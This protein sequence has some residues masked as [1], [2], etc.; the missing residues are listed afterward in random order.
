MVISSG[1][2]RKPLQ[3]GAVVPASGRE[4][5]ADLVD[6]DGEGWVGGGT[7]ML[8]LRLSGVMLDLK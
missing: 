2:T 4:C 5:A 6:R 1:K 3:T 7:G 8:A